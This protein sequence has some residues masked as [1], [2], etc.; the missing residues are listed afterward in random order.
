M[1]QFHSI[2][3]FIG[4]MSPSTSEAEFA[5][6]IRSC[7]AGDGLIRV[8]KRARWSHAFAVY[9]NHDTADKAIPTVYS[10]LSCFRFRI[11]FR[12]ILI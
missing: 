12:L 11:I 5:A 9:S 8:E 10:L 6:T 3:L 1:S 7:G 2:E 4:Y